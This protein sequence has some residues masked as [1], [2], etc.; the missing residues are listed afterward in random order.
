VQEMSQMVNALEQDKSES[1]QRFHLPG[2]LIVGE[3]S[4]GVGPNSD[5]RATND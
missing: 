5:V 4:I 1:F 2:Q 3:I